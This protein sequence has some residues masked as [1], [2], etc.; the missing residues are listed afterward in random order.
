LELL[1]DRSALAEA[2]AR[3]ASERGGQVS[4]DDV[5]RVLEALFGTVVDAGTLAEALRRD[6]TVSVMGFGSFHL[7]DGTAVL[8]PGQALN[9]YLN[10]SLD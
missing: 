4:V 1:V 5:G 7:Q 6:R 9:E 3:K 2:T 10:G 8:R